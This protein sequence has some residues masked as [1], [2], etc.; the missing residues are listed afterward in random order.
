MNKICIASS[1]LGHVARGIEAWADD[2]ASALA[3][4]GED[5]ILCKGAGE[6]QRD[7]D[8]VVP[9]WTRD[10]VKT[11][12]LLRSLPA[13]L[14]WRIGMGSG[15]AVEQTTFA[16]N[17]IKVLRAEDVDVLHVQDPF[18]ALQVQKAHRRGRITTRTILAHGTEEPLDFQRQI[19][20]LQHL[21]PWHHGQARDAGLDRDGWT[22][23]PNF[24]DTDHFR[25]GSNAALR[26]ELGIPRDAL[27]V[28]V[29][30]AI[31]RKHKRIDYVVNEFRTLL[32]RHPDLP[33]WLVVAGGREPE[34]DA[35]IAMANET[36]GDRVRFLVRFPRTRMADLYRAADVFS[37]GSLKEM[38]PIALLEA[39][40]S[41]LPCLVH[42]HPVMQWMIGAGGRAID[43]SLPGNLASA[44]AE[45]LTDPGESQRIGRAAR[46]HCCDH[47]STDVV[48][49]QIM[50]YYR[51]VGDGRRRAA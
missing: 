49:D 9:C 29:A 21:A 50:H 6:P 37:L 44:W 25:P 18:V 24:I 10:A 48:V 16:R 30:A 46:Q 43:L 31:K 8:R 41:G 40:A 22:T 15:Y 5:V 11:R 14:G 3:A 34:T 28:L 7:I 26:N 13:A 35:L 36:L 2:L 27:V 51:R 17:L 42:R 4:R 12:L 20:Y 39:T 45:W 38:M 1:G 33:A 32:D 23:I 19:T 47:F